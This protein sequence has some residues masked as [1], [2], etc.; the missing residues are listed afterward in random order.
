MGEVI[1]FRKPNRRPEA[2]EQLTLEI[3]GVAISETAP[4][5]APQEQLPGF[6]H[7]LQLCDPPELGWEIPDGVA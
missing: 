3:G 7:G 4:P 5:A 2:Y 6:P 1:N